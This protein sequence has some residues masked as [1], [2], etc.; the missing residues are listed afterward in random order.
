MRPLYQEII[1]PNLCYIGGGGEIAYWLQLK[2]MFESADVDFPILMLRDSV[3]LASEKQDRKRQALGLE[4]NDLFADE[5]EHTANL[6]RKHSKLQL[7]FSAQRSVLEKQFDDL[8]EMAKQ[9][10]PSFLGAVKAQKAKQLKGLE[11]LE[12]RLL[13]AEKKQ[14]DDIIGRGLALKSELFP[15]GGLQERKENFSAFYLEFG[16]RLVEKLMKNLDPLDPNF[17]IIVGD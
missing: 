2:S 14:L 17:R 12:K 16:D 4:W 9:T 6:A 13:R 15:G 5:S 3:L 8:L 11:N 10:H 1:L 7:D